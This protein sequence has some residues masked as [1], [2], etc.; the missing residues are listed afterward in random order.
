MLLCV[1]GTYLNAQNIFIENK[2]Q[3]PNFVYAKAKIPSGSIF[4]TNTGV[5]FWLNLTILIYLSQKN[6]K[7]RT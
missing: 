7:I 5:P 6:L 1:F 2:G 3:Y 4:G